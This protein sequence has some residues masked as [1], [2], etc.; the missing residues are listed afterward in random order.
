LGAGCA[1]QLSCS[2]KHPAL[3]DEERKKILS[4][5]QSEEAVVQGSR[6]FEEPCQLKTG[7]PEDAAMGLRELM[8]TDEK[9]FFAHVMKG[10]DGI[11]MEAQELVNT[12]PKDGKE[13]LEIV[14]YVI[15]QKTSEK[16]YANGIRDKGRS[17]VRPTYFLTHYNARDAKLTEGEVYSLRIYTMSAYKTI[18]NPL[19]DDLR[20]D[21]HKPVPMP[22]V[23]YL[24]DSA[25]RKLRA[26]RTRAGSSSDSEK[27]VVLWRG[28]RNVQV[29]EAFI[30]DGGTELAFMSTS[31]DV[32][33]AVRY[34]LSRHPLLFKIVAPN[35]MSLGA[36]LQWISAFPD[37]AEVLFP[38]LTFLQ[39][40]GRIDHVE[41]VDL[42]GYPVSFTVIEVNPSF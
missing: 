20:Y 40:T 41:T 1:G 11:E 8:Q 42:N 6:F 30:R 7:K 24:A 32:R 14:D 33:V 25:I 38:P 31:T 13:V 23:S 21:R 35:F 28:M 10:P 15:N 34:S 27:N 22:V 37:E 2:N 26:V 36:E 19:R 9:K 16:K 39:P 5:V 17:S 18:N 4:A 12:S 3:S 29:S